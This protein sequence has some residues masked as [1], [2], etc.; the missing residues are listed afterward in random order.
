MKRAEVVLLDLLLQQLYYF[1]TILNTTLNDSKQLSERHVKTKTYIRTT[2]HLL[3]PS[4]AF[5]YWWNKYFERLYKAMQECILK[6][7]PRPVSIIV[8]E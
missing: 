5:D 4:W 3:L 8:D 7:D 2:M 1:L 6:L